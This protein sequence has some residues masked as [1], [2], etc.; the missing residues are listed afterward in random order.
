MKLPKMNATTKL[1]TLFYQKTGELFYA[2]AAVDHRVRK[3]EFNGLKKSL[4]TY[5]DLFEVEEQNSSL[6][7][8]DILESSFKNAFRNKKDPETCYEEFVNYKSEKPE[9]FTISHNKAIWNTA[10]LIANSFSGA[11]KTEVIFL[12]KL[13]MVLLGT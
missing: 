7:P 5:W 8:V 3:E 2:I 13:K 10:N 1:P 9:L 4:N 11:N 12:Q 6:K